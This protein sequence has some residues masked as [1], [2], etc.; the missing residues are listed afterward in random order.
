MTDRIA[1]RL[2]H[3][4]Q[5]LHA[6]DGRERDVGVAHEHG[7]DP[8]VC[9]RVGRRIAADVREWSVVVG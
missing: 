5:R 4:P 3:D 7:L 1:K 2:L 8:G 6:Q 9:R